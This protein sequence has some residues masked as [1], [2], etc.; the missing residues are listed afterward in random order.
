M[1]DFLKT[2]LDHRHKSRIAITLKIFQKNRPVFMDFLNLIKDGSYFQ[3]A[4]KDR[5]HWCFYQW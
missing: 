5:N 3:F 1:I 2:F 4:N